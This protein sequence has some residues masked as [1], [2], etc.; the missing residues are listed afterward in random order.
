MKNKLS[1]RQLRQ[2]QLKKERE[3]KEMQERVKNIFLYTKP[4]KKY[5]FYFL[6]YKLQA[7]F[8]NLKLNFKKWQGK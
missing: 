1:K 3:K 4:P 5:Y 2:R 6:F 7:L 8:I